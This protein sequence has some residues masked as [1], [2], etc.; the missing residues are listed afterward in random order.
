VCR[1]EIL[2]DKSLE[3]CHTILLSQL[4]SFC[5]RCCHIRL[6]H[7]GNLFPELLYLHP[8][9]TLM[10]LLVI[11]PG[12]RRVKRYTRFVGKYVPGRRKHFR[13]HKVYIF[14]IRITN[15][16]DLVISVCPYERCDLGKYFYSRVSCVPQ[17]CFVS[18]PRS[19]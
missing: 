19:L 11:M 12:T 9:R 1:S 16:F 15:R 6:P 2:A 4:A 13:P 3:C 18:V 10:S 14:L 17:V 7:K 5:W 8:S